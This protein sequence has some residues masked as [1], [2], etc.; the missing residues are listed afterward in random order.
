MALGNGTD[1]TVKEHKIE[2]FLYKYE[3]PQQKERRANEKKNRNKNVTIRWQLRFVIVQIIFD[4][5]Y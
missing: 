2:D 1:R 4:F 5:Y 3:I